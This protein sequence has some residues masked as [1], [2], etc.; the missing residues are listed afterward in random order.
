MGI[1]VLVTVLAYRRIAVAGRLMV[2]LWIGMLVTVAW[3]IV[4]G[5]THFDPALAFDF[6]AGAWRLDRRTAMGLGMALAI[7]MYD[8]LGYYQI[9]YLG[10]EV[11]DASRTIP[12]SILIS[13]V[14]VAVVYLVDEHRHSGRAALAGGRSR[15]STSPAT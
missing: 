3:V 10:D 9:C 11:A 2:V 4:T 1:M 7:A 6:P 15:R 13:V 12:R 14:A 5:L 8:F